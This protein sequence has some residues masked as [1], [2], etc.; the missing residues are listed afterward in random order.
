MLRRLYSHVRG[1]EPARADLALGL[2]VTAGALV[3]IALSDPHGHDKWSTAAVA[4]PGL[5]FPLAWR[6]RD[7]L[8]SALVF[9]AVA[10]LS[11][12]LDT[13][14][15]S[16]VDVAFLAL[17][18]LLYSVGRHS[19]GVRFWIA[20]V[21]LTVGID[22]AL[23]TYPDN[24][25]V[26]DVLWTV[27]LFTPPILAGRTMRS[28]TRLQ[29]EL[30]E[31]ARLAEEERDVRAAEAAVRER[32]RIAEELQAVV[33]NAV[34]AIVVQAEAIPRAYATGR[35]SQAAET[36]GAIEETGRDALAEMRRLLGVLRRE[37]DGPELAPQP[38][39]ARLGALIGRVRGD[40]LEVELVIEGDERTPAPGVDLT[41]YRVIE[42][43]LEAAAEQGATQ[44]RVEVRYGERDLDVAVRDDRSGGASHHL[45][46][47]RDRVGLYG[48]HLSAG[49]ADE[50]F[51]LE[52]RL[53]L[54]ERA[55]V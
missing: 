49:P 21:A 10:G 15:M 4:I 1:L 44:A 22:A 27:L 8:L 50:G 9:V 30:R 37:D 17:V 31:R 12:Q 38:G 16:S 7:P 26:E 13:F 2:V 39:L 35:G 5:V 32:Q 52:S 18:V 6:R 41:A 51:A 14:Y 42:D 43:A 19:D 34:S 53:P 23:L 55:A 47:L 20:A 36:F 11:T 24:E 33:A 3:E 40:G 48:G 28:R 29:T 25:G 54:E 46:G 45:A